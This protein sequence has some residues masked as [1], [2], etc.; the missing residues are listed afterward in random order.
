MHL[1]DHSSTNNAARVGIGIRDRGAAAFSSGNADLA[2]GTPSDHNGNR[3]LRSIRLRI[4]DQ[5]KNRN[6]SDKSS[7][8][9][10]RNLLADRAIQ[11]NLRLRLAPVL[12][13]RHDD[14]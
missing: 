4:G 11:S 3:P 6:D 9:Y 1:S 14:I 12:Q 2:A 7:I 10:A 5:K 8:Q 13:R